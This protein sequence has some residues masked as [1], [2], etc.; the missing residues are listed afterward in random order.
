MIYPGDANRR[1]SYWRRL[2]R[3]FNQASENKNGPE[4]GRF[5]T[6]NSDIPQCSGRRRR[7]LAMLQ[8]TFTTIH[9]PSLGGFERDCG[10]LPAT[11]TSRGCFHSYAGGTESLVALSLAFL[12]SLRFV[13]EVFR[14]I[15][16]LFT[17]RKNK[18]RPAI[19]A[20]KHS[21]LVFHGVLR[22]A[23]LPE[24]LN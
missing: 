12:A 7:H 4:K 20:H 18:F 16:E 23:N 3:P 15:E 14:S 11:R 17:R 8:E 13:S 24:I 2:S 9:G 1:T 5:H 22:S 10:F 21:V 6:C 19:H